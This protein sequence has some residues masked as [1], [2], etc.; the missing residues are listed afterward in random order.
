MTAYDL[1]KAWPELDL[2]IVPD[3]GHSSVE[4]GTLKL[5]VEVSLKVAT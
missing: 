2:Q 3:A 1:K 5:L 4:P